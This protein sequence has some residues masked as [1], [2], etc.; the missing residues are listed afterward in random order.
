MPQPSPQPA[1]AW[2][3]LKRLLPAVVLLLG[4][5]AFFAGG[6]H[7]YVGFDTLERP[8][9]ALMALVAAHRLAAPLPFVAL[10]AVLVAFPLP[11]APV[12]PV[13][14]GFSFGTLARPAGPVAG[15]PLGPLAV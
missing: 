1:G 9:D 14:A 12:I 8:H 6:G 2:P 13:A 15:A 11:L 7:R 4:L 3:V 5:V 10:Y